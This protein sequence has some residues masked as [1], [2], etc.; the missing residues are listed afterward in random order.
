MKTLVKILFALLIAV[1][2]VN[3]AGA[4]SQ[5]AI[6]EAKKAA[7]IKSLIDSKNYIFQ[8]SY[9]YPSGGG[10]RYLTSPYDLTVSPDTVEAYLPYF[11]VAYSG[12]GYNSSDDNGIKFKSTRFDY[13]AKT[14]KDGSYTI[15]IKAN[16]TRNA[17]QMT[18]QVY[19]NGN[20]DLT[21]VSMNR[22][23]I[24]FNGYIKERSKP[25]V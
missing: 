24:R 12:A 6:K 18:L 1:A 8:A 13:A 20:A 2:V 23:Q 5:K 22:Q 15:N 11:G 16:D 25:K 9:M 7:E 14:K 17:T 19:T 3:P 4:Q 21:V 10:S